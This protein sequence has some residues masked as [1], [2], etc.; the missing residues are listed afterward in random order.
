MQHCS[1]RMQQLVYSFMCGSWSRKFLYFRVFQTQVHSEIPVNMFNFRTFNR[2][3][4]FLLHS[5]VLDDDVL[6]LHCRLSQM[7]FHLR[8]L[9][10]LHCFCMVHSDVLDNDVVLRNFYILVSAFIASGAFSCKQHIPLQISVIFWCF[11]RYIPNTSDFR[12]AID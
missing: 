10:I 9:Q 1:V 6:L 4:R 7:I 3:D 2:L 12:L 5:K 11:L 8:N